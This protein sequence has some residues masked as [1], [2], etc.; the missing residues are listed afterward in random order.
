MRVT[1]TPCKY[2]VCYLMCHHTAPHTL[3]ELG[4]P[5]AREQP[6]PRLVCL[7]VLVQHSLVNKCFQAR[8]SVATVLSVHV[9]VAC[10]LVA[11][12]AFIESNVEF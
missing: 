11:C 4:E 9:H 6:S 8:R 2:S 1:R 5:D 7:L 12:Y 10:R 3:H